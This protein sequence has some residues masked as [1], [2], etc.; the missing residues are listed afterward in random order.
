MSDS[1]AISEQEKELWDYYI[2]HDFYS[3]Q[4]FTTAVVGIGA[5]LFAFATSLSAHPSTRIVIA[6]VGLFASLILFWDMKS[7]SEDKKEF[8]NFMKIKGSKLVDQFE[9]FRAWRHIRKHWYSVQFFPLRKL[10][11]LSCCLWPMCGFFSF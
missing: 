6:L 1:A 5:L 10:V 7:T 3:F 9:E 8:Q 4:E 11:E 2:N